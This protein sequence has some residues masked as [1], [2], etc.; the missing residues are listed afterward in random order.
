M[1]NIGAMD[2][3]FTQLKD[4]LPKAAARHGVS[5]EVRAAHVCDRAKRALSGMEGVKPLYFKDGVLMLEVPNSAWAQ[6]VFLKKNKIIEEVGK[7]VK[8]VR[9]RVK[10]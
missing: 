10:G 3:G 9:T 6:E 7:G 1:L 4:L 5:R 2:N 8:E